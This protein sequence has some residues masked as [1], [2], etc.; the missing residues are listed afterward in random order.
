MYPT[1]G[2]PVACAAASV[3]AALY[4]T[5]STHISSLLVI[6]RPTVEEGGRNSMCSTLGA[7]VDIVSCR[8][9][10]R[11]APLYKPVGGSG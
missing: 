6:G 9:R 3:A 1:L 4:N 7:P 11:L 5:I 2:T 10:G 8:S